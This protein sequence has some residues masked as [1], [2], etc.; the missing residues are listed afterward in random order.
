MQISSRFTIA[1]QILTCIDVFQDKELLTSEFLASSV[2]VNPVIIRK[3]LQQLKAAEIVSVKRGAGGASLARKK[4]DITL[5][6]VFEAVESLENG[7]LFHFHDYP[8][9]NDPVGRNIHAVLDPRLLQVQEAMESAMKSMTLA[10]VTADIQPY[11]L[12]DEEERAR[13]RASYDL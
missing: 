4:S 10:E 12:R 7:Q 6:D 11:I 8:N 2:N 1:L 9:P 5:F 3:I 13:K